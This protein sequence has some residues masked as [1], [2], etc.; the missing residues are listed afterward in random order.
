MFPLIQN[1]ITD[2]PFDHKHEWIDNVIM[3]SGIEIPISI[4]K[5]CHEWHGRE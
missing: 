1:S 5:K 3:I 4:C 2:I